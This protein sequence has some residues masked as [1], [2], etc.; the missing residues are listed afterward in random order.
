MYTPYNMQYIYLVLILS[1]FSVISIKPKLCINCK[2]FNKYFM[3]D[4]FSKCALFPIVEEDDY[5][6]VNGKKNVK[7]LDY[8]YCSVCRIYDEMC[9]KDGKLYEKN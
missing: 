3:D 9:G 5:F 6:L 2:H 7:P 8:H 4:K 1:V